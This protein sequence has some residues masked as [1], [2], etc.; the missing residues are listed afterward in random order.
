MLIKKPVAP[1]T[2]WQ[3]GSRGAGSGRGFALPCFFIVPGPVEYVQP[4]WI[5]FLL[6]CSCNAQLWPVELYRCSWEPS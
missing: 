2:H 6:L 4:S 5:I 1:A 3:A